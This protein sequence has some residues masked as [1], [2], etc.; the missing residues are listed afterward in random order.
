MAEALASGGDLQVLS[1]P[2]PVPP[3]PIAHHWLK[4]READPDIG[5]LLAL[6]RNLFKTAQ[7]QDHR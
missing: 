1:P 4:R 2:F 5:W 6:S 3:I 7:P